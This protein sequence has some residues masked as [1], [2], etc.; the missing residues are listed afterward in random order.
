MI[1]I[2]GYTRRTWTFKKIDMIVQLIG[3][4]HRNANH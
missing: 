2:T 4:P 1:K 3:C